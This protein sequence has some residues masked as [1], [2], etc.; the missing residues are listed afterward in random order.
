MKHIGAIVAEDQFEGLVEYETV[1]ELQAFAAG[2]SKGAGLYG[3]G[4]CGL[5]TL[6]DLDGLN[7]NDEYDAKII[8][9]ASGPLGRT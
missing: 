8:A 9:E 6:E 4:G 5:Y 2:L 1:A 3:A 7:P